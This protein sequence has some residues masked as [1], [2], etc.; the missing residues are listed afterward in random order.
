[1]TG[2]GR[3]ANGVIERYVVDGLVGGTRG[4][5]G[6]AGGAVRRA[7][8]GFVRFYALAVVAG[9]AGLGLYFLIVAS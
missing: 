5:V 2:F 6:G 9:I 4:F 8:S 7:Q 3:F 1:M